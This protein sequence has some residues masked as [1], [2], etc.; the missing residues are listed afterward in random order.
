MWHSAAT[1]ESCWRYHTKSV[2]VFCCWSS[3]FSWASVSSPACFIA[4]IAIAVSRMLPQLFES[5]LLFNSATQSSKILSGV[6][7]IVSATSWVVRSEQSPAFSSRHSKPSLI[8]SGS[9]CDSVVVSLSAILMV[10]ENSNV[11]IMRNA[12]SFFMDEYC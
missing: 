4:R 8:L 9:C 12:P 2:G 11:S 3:H 7:K 1:F 6:A 5:F 10:I